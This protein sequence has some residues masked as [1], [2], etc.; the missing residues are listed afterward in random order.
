MGQGKEDVEHGQVGEGSTVPN[1]LHPRYIPLS[2][3]ERVRSGS[4]AQHRS[5]YG[6][7]L[8]SQRPQ[9]GT[10]KIPHGAQATAPPN[11]V[12]PH[13]GG[14]DLRG[15]TEVRSKT[16]CKGEEEER[17]DIGGHVET[18]RR[19]SLRATKDK[20]PDTDLEADP[21]N[22]GKPKKGQETK[23]RDSGRVSG[24]ATWGGTANATGSMTAAQRMVQGCSRPCTAARSSYA[25]TYHGRTG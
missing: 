13:A 2:L 8:P 4:K 24:G 11:T 7:G 6:A 12:R 15:P 16:T 3:L 5:I 10:H 22:C 17:V 14:R 19:E 1:G 20:G 25:R 23:S 21:S 18:R 9:E